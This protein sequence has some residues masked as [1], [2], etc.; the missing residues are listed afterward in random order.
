MES[1]GMS[2]AD[3]LL[4]DA[5]KR[6]PGN[7][8]KIRIRDLLAHWNAKLRGYWIVERIQDDLKTAKLTTDPPFTEGWIDTVITLVPVRKEAKRKASSST[9]PDIVDATDRSLPEVSLTVGSLPSSNLGVVSV[10]PQDSLERH[11]H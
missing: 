4:R 2:S 7:E 3:D 1:G 6:E 5:A 10:S 9:S 11:N 8:V